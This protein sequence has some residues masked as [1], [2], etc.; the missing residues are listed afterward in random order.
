LNNHAASSATQSNLAGLAKMLQENH[1][2]EGD[3]LREFAG[4]SADSS[5]DEC[6]ALAMKKTPLD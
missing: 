5:C 3:F 1:C 6:G 4:D 2:G